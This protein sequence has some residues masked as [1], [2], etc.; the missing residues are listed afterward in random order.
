MFGRHGA[1]FCPWVLK[2]QRGQL[3]GKA[4]AD[5]SCRRGTQITVSRGKKEKRGGGTKT[6]TERK[7]K[8][9]VTTLSGQRNPRAK[10]GGKKRGKNAWKRTDRVLDVEISAK[11]PGGLETG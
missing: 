3:K 8:T 6:K 7:A 4:K 10:N 11:M 2:G 9:K 5:K 1:R